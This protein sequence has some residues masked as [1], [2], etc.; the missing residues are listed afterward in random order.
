GAITAVVRTNALELGID[1]GSFQAA[2][3]GGYPGPIAATWQHPGGAGGRRG[4]GGGGVPGLGAPPRLV[5]RPA[6]RV[7]PQ[8][9]PRGRPHRSRQSLAARRPSPGRTVRAALRIRRAARAYGCERAS[10]P[11]RGGW[12]GD[13]VGG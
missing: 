5:H 1:I 11:L 4:P 9:R 12:L 8:H 6:A 2:I 13:A 3:L 7:L 10:A